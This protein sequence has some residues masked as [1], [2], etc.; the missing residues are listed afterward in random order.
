MSVKPGPGGPRRKNFYTFNTFHVS[1][2]INR[3]RDLDK[4]IPM[5]MF[6]FKDPKNIDKNDF[7]KLYP[8]V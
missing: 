7:R 4:F 1:P 2:K 3:L 8:T 5:C 6:Q